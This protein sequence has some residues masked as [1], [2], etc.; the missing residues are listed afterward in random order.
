MYLIAELEHILKKESK[1]LDI[2]GTIVRKI[3]KTLGTKL[4]TN[5]YK[6]GK[7]INQIGDILKIYCYRNNSKFANYLKSYDTKTK[8]FI[9]VRLK[10]AYNTI[11]GKKIKVK[12][13]H[14]PIITRINNSRN[15]T[16]HGENSYLIG[17]IFF[18]LTLH[19]IYYLLNENVYKEY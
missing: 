9:K 14:T 1:Y 19:S 18:Y 2:D 8:A 10:D 17:E 15:Q 13:I 4:Y 5:N 7:R 3:P 11:N 6:I 12:Y 16:M